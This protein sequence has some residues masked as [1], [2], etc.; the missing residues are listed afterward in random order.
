MSRLHSRG[1]TD[2]SHGELHIQLS[3]STHW[4]F[5]RDVHMSER[6]EDKFP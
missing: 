2:D 6:I 3:N 1:G 4:H 5:R